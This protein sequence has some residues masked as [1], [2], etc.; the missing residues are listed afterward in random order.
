MN[1]EGGILLRPLTF[2]LWHCS[3]WVF[4]LFLVR[5][6]VIRQSFFPL[7]HGKWMG[8]VQP[9]MEEFEDVESVSV[10]E[11]PERFKTKWYIMFYMKMRME[12]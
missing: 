2:D 5:L 10:E 3:Y 12:E 9:V 1:Q 11:I 4:L 7:Y 6:L 8:I